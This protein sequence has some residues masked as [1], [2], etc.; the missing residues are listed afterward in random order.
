MRTVP[1]VIL[2]LAVAAVAGGVLIEG[3]AE[4]PV[5]MLVPYS[6][7]TCALEIAR[8]RKD[9]WF[10]LGLVPIILG[11]S[12]G[13]VGWTLCAA[14]VASPAS[15]LVWAGVAVAVAV[16]TEAI[17]AKAHGTGSHVC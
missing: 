8:R 9:A 13:G 10:K 14:Y 12:A 6:C 3:T 17:S 2:L 16:S 1:I 4:S 5:T 7:A 11:L 15:M